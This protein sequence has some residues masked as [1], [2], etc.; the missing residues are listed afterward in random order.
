MHEGYLFL[1]VARRHGNDRSTYVGG[2]VVSAKT[3]G[4]QAVAVAHLEDVILSSTIC[5]EGTTD[6]LGPHGEVFASVQDDN[7]LAGGTRR[8]VYTHNLAHGHG[9]KAKWVVIA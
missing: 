8:G 2:T 5:C 7:R 6:G 4:E 3:S 9:G 1:S